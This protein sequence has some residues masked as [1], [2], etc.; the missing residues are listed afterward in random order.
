MSNLDVYMKD[1]PTWIS[2]EIQKLNDK[3]NYVNSEYLRASNSQYSEYFAEYIKNDLQS[4]NNN[5]PGCL[6]RLSAYKDMIIAKIQ[7][8]ISFYNSI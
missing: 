5:V 7:L 2:N 6:T 4:N 1:K 3:I 8:E